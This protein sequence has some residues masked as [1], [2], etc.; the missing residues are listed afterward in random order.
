MAFDIT[1]TPTALRD[2]TAAVEY[3]NRKAENYQ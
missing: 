3:Y 1:I 2:I